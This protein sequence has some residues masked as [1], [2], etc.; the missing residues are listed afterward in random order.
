M[1][2][3]WCVLLTVPYGCSTGDAIPYGWHAS[4]DAVSVR[5]AGH[6]PPHGPGS[7]STNGQRGVEPRFHGNAAT[8]AAAATA[9]ATATAASWGAASSPAGS[10]SETGCALL[11][12]STH[13]HPSLLSTHLHSPPFFAKLS[14][15]G[16]VSEGCLP[17]SQILLNCHPPS[18]CRIPH[19]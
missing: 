14:N 3:H 5:T 18:I 13:L 15:S 4:H 6:V 8:A 7:R 16:C 9:T 12:P 19:A 17:P 10:T 1:P 11:P 2:V